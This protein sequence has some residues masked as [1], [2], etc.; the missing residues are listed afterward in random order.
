MRLAVVGTPSG[1]VWLR[2]WARGWRHVG[3][4]RQP[5]AVQIHVG[6]DVTSDPRPGMGRLAMVIGGDRQLWAYDGAPGQPW[7][8]WGL[9][10]DTTALAGGRAVVLEMLRPQPI[11]MTLGADRGMWLATPEQA[12]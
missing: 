2:D 1:H 3:G 11:A 10:R 5:G 4:H 6:V 9:P 12:V 7:E 8:R